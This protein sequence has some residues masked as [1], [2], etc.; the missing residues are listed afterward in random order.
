MPCRSEYLDRNEREKEASICSKFL[1][2]LNNMSLIS[3]S[4]K[5]MTI[6]DYQANDYYGGQLT[7]E[8]II[9]NKKYITYSSDELTKVLC[10]YLSSLDNEEYTRLIK[11]N[12]MISSEL[13]IWWLKHKKF[14]EL[15]KIEEYLK[16]FKNKKVMLTYYSELNGCKIKMKTK[17][18]K[19]QYSSK[20]DLEFLLDFTKGNMRW[21]PDKNV[22]FID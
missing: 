4:E 20:G 16:S 7:R 5:D 11:S 8:V 2:Y 17:I 14:D 3:F 13:N 12:S 10:D 15:R 6:L 18:L 19:A 22:T 1:I 9:E 21:Y